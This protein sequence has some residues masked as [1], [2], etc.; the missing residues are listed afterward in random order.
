[1]LTPEYLDTIDDGMT[2]IASELEQYIIGEIVERLAARLARGEKMMFT[3]YDKWQM[4]VLEEA[5]VLYKRIVKLVAKYSGYGVAEIRRALKAAGIESV[6]NDSSMLY[7][8]GMPAETLF[9]A[10]G[11]IDPNNFTPA[12]KALLSRSPYYVR[13]AERAYNATNGTWQ[14]MTQTQAYTAYNS[15]VSAMDRVYKKTVSGAVS[16][17]KALNDEITDLAKHGMTM[18]QSINTGRM[19]HIDV[20]AARCIRTGVSQMTA[21]ITTARM[22]EL[23]IDL[24]LVTAHLGARPDHEVWQGKVYSRK[25]KT[26]KYDD[27][28]TATGY[29]TGAGLCGWNCKHSFYPYIEGMHNPYEDNPID[30]EENKRRY[31]LTQTQRKYERAIRQSKRVKHIFETVYKVTKDDE[32]KKKLDAEKDRLRSLNAAYTDFCKANDLRHM[33]E[34]LKAIYG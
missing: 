1:M 5:G 9:P 24:V 29:G 11:K 15:F 4:Q 34:R 14:N 19:E 27:F 21:E 2:A 23:D 12:A 18:V 25:G 26:D 32:I 16:Y 6:V 31:G 10:F 20:A 7:S 33:T 17:T 22:D 30:T 28:V 8:G 3:A 13:A